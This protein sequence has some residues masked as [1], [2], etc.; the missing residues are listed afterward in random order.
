LAFDFTALLLAWWYVSD[1]LTREVEHWR[2]RKHAEIEMER[3]SAEASERLR[4]IVFEQRKSSS[5][6]NKAG[7]AGV[8]VWWSD[9]L[10]LHGRLERRTHASALR[11]PGRE[12]LEDMKPLETLGCGCIIDSIERLWPCDEHR[13]DPARLTPTDEGKAIGSAEELSSLR[14]ELTAERSA[15]QQAE[16]ERDQL[17]SALV[18]LVGVDGRE[19]LEQMEGV[20]RLM[21]A[22]AQDKAMTIDAI[23][24]LIASL[25]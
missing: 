10:C 1:R 5:I 19:D 16:R 23:H 11:K 14:A 3:I 22:P 9:A 15:R 13:P 4:G 7:D 6:L 24:A 18:G 20:M 17:R 12:R 25:P 21:P 8:V 2:Q